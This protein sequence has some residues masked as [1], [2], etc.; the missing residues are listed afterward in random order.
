[1]R[2]PYLTASIAVIFLLVGCTS[3]I[4]DQKTQTKEN[5]ASIIGSWG[6]SKGHSIEIE[7]KPWLL[8]RKDGIFEAYDG[9]YPVYGTWSESIDG[10]DLMP[11][12]KTALPEGCKEIWAGKVDSLEIENNLITIKNLEGEDLINLSLVS[13][14]TTLIAEE[15]SIQEVN[16]D[17][18]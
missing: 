12:G 2:L 14:D 5:S 17:Y 15:K 3:S 11:Q 6:T 7:S 8:I 18:G 16:P 13:R 4:E 10:V 1:M 9:C